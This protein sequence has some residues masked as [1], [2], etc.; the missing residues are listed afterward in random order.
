MKI[1]F[2]GGM[3]GGHFYPLI[4]VAER[5]RKIEE[6]DKLEKIDLFFFSSS[7]FDEKAL[8]DLSIKYVNVP[9]GKWRLSFSLKNIRDI[10]LMGVGFFVALIKLF[11][12]YP[13]VIFS[14]GGGASVPVV[15]AAWTLRIPVIIHESDSVPGKANKFLSRFAKFVAISYREAGEY[16]KKE[17]V[18]FT[19]HPIREDIRKP[20]REGAFE[21]LHLE[22]N[23][24]VIFVVGGSQGAR[25]INDALL[26]ALPEILR[27]CQVIHMVGA[28]S[29]EE[30]VML[31]KQKLEDEESL[32]ERY[33]PFPY[34]FPVALRMVAGVSD[35]VITRAGS[36]LFEVA[37]WGIPSIVIPI[38]HSNGD[39]QRRNAFLY[40]K[41]GAGIVIEE[42]NLQPNLL[43]QEIKRILEDKSIQDKMINGAKKVAEEDGARAIAEELVNVARSHT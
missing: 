7:P 20:I 43:V 28:K 18:V 38:T 10:F 33:R 6:I 9:S 4:A 19:G 8:D 12:V 16:F 1:G 41:S 21:Y 23:V 25:L 5:V 26:E 32:L 36:M 27:N 37:S 24:P 39:H 42:A 11:Q 2:A 22:P 17:K 34:L 30:V 29:Y 15:L 3:S 13:D 14:K 31:S 40:A 35:L